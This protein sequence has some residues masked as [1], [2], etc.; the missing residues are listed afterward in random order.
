MTRLNRTFSERLRVEGN[1]ELAALVLA[2]VI[3]GLSARSGRS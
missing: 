3:F 2:F 1:R